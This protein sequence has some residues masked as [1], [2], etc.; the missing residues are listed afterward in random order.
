MI[1]SDS[2]VALLDFMDLYSINPNNYVLSD[3]SFNEELYKETIC[4]LRKIQETNE[5]KFLCSVYIIFDTMLTYKRL[6]HAQKKL[7]EAI[8]N[9]HAQEK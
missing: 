8:L 4:K 6:F 9:N 7:T 1:E 2:A 3:G 5:D